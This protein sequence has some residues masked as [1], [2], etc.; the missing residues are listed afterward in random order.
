MTK[1]EKILYKIEGGTAEEQRQV[2]AAMDYLLSP[3]A[4]GIGKNLLNKAYKL[5][6]KPVI[7]RINDKDMIG[8]GDFG[9]E[10]T[11]SINF[12]QLNCSDYVD[13]KGNSYKPSL[14]SQLAH[15]LTHAGQKNIVNAFFQ[16]IE[17]E[18]MATLEIIGQDGAKKWNKILLDVVSSKTYESAMQKLENFVDNFLIPVTPNIIENMSNRKEFI[19]HI[20]DIEKPAVSIERLVS[21]A[22]NSGIRKDYINTPELSPDIT[23]RIIIDKYAMML[24]IDEKPHRKEIKSFRQMVKKSRNTKDE[25]SLAR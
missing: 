4:W 14:E 12:D 2:Q 11:V 13:Y 24:G 16:R 3:Q 9:G 18:N 6:K 15:E 8:Y 21:S 23:R 1:K 17:L 19:K 20:E 22:Q 25:V 5:H 7:I 10:N